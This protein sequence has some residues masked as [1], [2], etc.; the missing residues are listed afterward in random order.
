MEL[1]VLNMQ[2]LLGFVWQVV[3]FEVLNLF[4]V[5]IAIINIFL[6]FRLIFFF[7][8]QADVVLAFNIERIHPVQLYLEEL[9]ELQL[10]CFPA[11]GKLVLK[12]G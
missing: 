8:L 12:L 6:L 5:D 10:F 2:C 3:L 4:R 1:L 11:C 7:Q 9:D